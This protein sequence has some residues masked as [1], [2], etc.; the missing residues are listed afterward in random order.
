[1]AELIILP[2]FSDNRGS[3]NVVESLKTINFEVKRIYYMY[4][5][6]KDCE[7]GGHR[8]KKTIQ[9]L[10]CVHG[11]CKIYIENEFEQK[12]FQLNSPDICLIVP[13]ED[14]HTMHS[15]S[16]NAVL[17]VLASEHYDKDDYID[18]KYL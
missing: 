14:W 18:E 4:G 13:P 2:V 10:I 8:H 5:I 15:F 9:A 7:R 11:D 6:P 17:L 12:E 3:L 1:M 16:N